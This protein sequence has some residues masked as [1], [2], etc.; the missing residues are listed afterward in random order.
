MLTE[1]CLCSL[2]LSVSPYAYSEVFFP[3]CWWVWTTPLIRIFHTLA[4]SPL[5]EVLSEL[6]DLHFCYFFLSFIEI[7]HV[8]TVCYNSICFSIRDKEPRAPKYFS[9]EYLACC[10]TVLAKYGRDLKATTTTDLKYSSLLLRTCVFSHQRV[11]WTLLKA[12]GV[13]S[14]ITSG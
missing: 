5:C 3:R 2:R 12:F 7:V 4:K 10:L 6:L 1:A 8:L 13:E 9:L 11:G 14:N